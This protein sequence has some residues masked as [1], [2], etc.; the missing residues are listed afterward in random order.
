VKAWPVLGDPS[1]L[2]RAIRIEAGDDRLVLSQSPSLVLGLATWTLLALVAFGALAAG[3]ILFGSQTQRLVCDRTAGSF[4][5]N[6][7]PLAP[8]PQV[9]GAELRRT[10]TRSDGT[11]YTLVLVLA[12]HTEREACIQSVQSDDSVAE[13]K[14]VAGAVRTFLA[15]PSQK[16]FDATYAYRASLQEKILMIVRTAVMAGIASLLWLLHER[17][18]YSFDRKSGRVMAS[19]KRLL[20]PARKWDLGFDR[21][22]AVSESRSGPLQKIELRLVEGAGVPIFLS[23]RNLIPESTLLQLEQALGKPRRNDG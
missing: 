9:T 3:G 4:E 14:A 10:W 11:F 1:L 12:D 6:G 20:L 16:H 2:R 8:L 22:A 7:R 5:L 21:I 17:V 13:Y 19:S 23:S 15:D 18:R